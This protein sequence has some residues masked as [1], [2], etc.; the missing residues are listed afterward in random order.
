MSKSEKKEYRSLKGM[1]DILPQDQPYWERVRKYARDLGSIYSFLRI[2]T[3]I[4]EEEL[5]F[6]RG[7]GGNTELISKQMYSFK[8]KGGDAVTLRPEGTP[9]VA[10]SYIQHG[11][12]SLPQPVKFYY[13]GP[14]FRY[15]QPQS[16]RYRQLHQYGLEIIGESS[17]MHDVQIIQIAI[18][19]LQNLGLKGINAEINS[20]GCRQCRP[21]YIKVLKDSLKSKSKKLCSDCRNRIKNNPL[22]ILDCKDEKCRQAL[23]DV[24]NTVD[25]LCDECHNH[26]KRVLELLDELEIPY[27]LNPLLVRGLDY[28]SKTVFELFSGEQDGETPQKIALGGGGRYD[29]LIKD[30][31]G[32]DTPGVGVGLGLDRII[33]LMKEQGVKLPHSASPKIFLV[34]LGDLGKAKSFKLFND[35]YRAGIISAEA[36]GKDSIKSQLKIADRMGVKISL[37][38]GQQEALDGTVIIRDMTAGVQETVPY[39]RVVSEVKKRLKQLK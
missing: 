11:M 27:F 25:H 22:R 9:S 37:I 21:A 14:F 12:A 20:I 1:H 36:L 32:K 30:L 31:G 24:P 33:S 29:Y 7:T 15:E 5:L 34:Q 17:P 4:L 28:Y 39:D 13:I 6:E 19:F 38:M 23:V 3:P 8:T 2:D 16:G 10:R 35:L 18:I 26:F